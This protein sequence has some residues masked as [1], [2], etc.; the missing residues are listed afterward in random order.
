MSLTEAM[1]RSKLAIDAHAGSLTDRLAGGAVDPEIFISYSQADH[2][3]AEALDR[4]LR[5]DGYTTWWAATLVGGDA[6]HMAIT[7]ALEAA[8]AVIVLWTGV[9]IRS[10]WVR[11]EAERARVRDKLIPVRVLPLDYADIPPPFNTIFTI[12]C[13]R[14]DAVRSALERLGVRQRPSA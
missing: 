7:D 4:D 3:V 8:R 11:G 9:S 13:G 6:S 2:A 10:V 12:D 5:E 1:R 14:Q